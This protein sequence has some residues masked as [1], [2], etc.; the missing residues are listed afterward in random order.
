[1]RSC[2]CLVLAA[3]AGAGCV[4]PATDGEQQAP[5]VGGTT[6]TGDPAVVLMINGDLNGGYVSLCSGEVI[7]PHV[8]LTAAHCTDLKPPYNVYLGDDINRVQP[9]DLIPATATANPMYVKNSQ[10]DNYDVGVLV[11]STPV[12]S[13][14]TPL[15]FNV[16]TDPSTLVGQSIRMVGYGSTGS[17]SPSDTSSGTKR[18]VSTILSKVQTRMLEFDDGSHNTC[19]GDS[20]GPAFATINGVETIIG[21]TAIG[22][23]AP[24]STTCD[25]ESLDTRVDLYTDFIQSFIDANDPP[26]VVS[27][28]PG[29]PGSIGY[30]CTSDD[31]C[32]SMICADLPNGYCTELCSPTT[33]GSCPS[34]LHCEQVGV[35][36][37]SEYACAKNQRSSGCSMSGGAESSSAPLVLVGALLL[38]GLAWRRRISS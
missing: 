22:L 3:F 11:L 8:I 14:I 15:P 9:S 23:M 30:R 21:L 13:T 33:A 25:G 24:G 20:G 1:M 34:G 17:T 5:I 28:A 27:S 12:P 10:D 18:T 31:E 6:D 26:P 35:S 32:N 7:S 2:S 37:A 4:P 36:P 38:L 19:E 16:T 29:T